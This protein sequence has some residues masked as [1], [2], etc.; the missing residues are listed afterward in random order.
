M[1]KRHA[2]R[3]VF[4]SGEVLGGLGARR[5]LAEIDVLCYAQD[6]ELAENAKAAEEAIQQGASLVHLSLFAAA[7]AAAAPLL[8]LSFLLAP[9]DAIFP[10]AGKRPPRKKEDLPKATE[11]MKARDLPLELDRNL[12][13]TIVID[14]SVGSGQ[15]QPGFYCDVCKRTC[16]DSA[17][18][19]DHINGRTRELLVP[20]LRVF[21]S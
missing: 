14:A 8:S 21:N 1:R 7:A 19:L 15:K 5:S 6:Q 17:R 12:N 20:R 10:H 4:H 9:T 3:C 16:K 18:Y 11:M 13:K 2:Q